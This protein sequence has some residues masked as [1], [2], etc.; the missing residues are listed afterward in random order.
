MPLYFFHLHGSAP[1]TEGQELA[2]DE[3]ARE[4]ARAVAHDLA[5]NRSIAPGERLIVLNSNG[6]V[7]HEEQLNGS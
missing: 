4:E 7:V 5:Q 2:D 1:D 3:T 6:K